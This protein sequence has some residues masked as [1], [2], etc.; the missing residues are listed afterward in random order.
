MT[1]SNLANIRRKKMLSQN[2][3]VKISGISRS[4]ITKYES[5]EK[6]IKKA[7]VETVFKIATSLKCNVE[8]LIEE[9]ESIIKD[10]KKND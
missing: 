1:M 2:D 3:L 10:I 7:A 5:G 4:L 8:D 6:N 9:K